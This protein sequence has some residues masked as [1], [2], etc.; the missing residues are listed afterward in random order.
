MVQEKKKVGKRKATE[1]ENKLGVEGRERHFGEENEK[2]DYK[3]GLW[4]SIRVVI[5]RSRVR[6]PQKNVEKEEKKNNKKER[7]KREKKKKK[8]KAEKKKKT[9]KKE[10]NKK[11]NNKKEKKLG[12]E[13]QEEW[14]QRMYQKTRK[15]QR[16]R[17]P[18]E[19]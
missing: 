14:G 18:V 7:K 6:I 1:K 9:Y 5:E 2:K 16:V 13:K 19:I 8:K 15:G 11:E 3:T 4:S 12:K 10:E 17:L